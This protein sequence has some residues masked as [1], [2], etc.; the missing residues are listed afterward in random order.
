MKKAILFACTLTLLLSCSDNKNKKWEVLELEEIAK[1]ALNKPVRFVTDSLLLN[2]DK[3]TFMDEPPGVISSVAVHYNNE[4][5]IE[6]LFPGTSIISNNLG[7]KEEYLN[8]VANKIINEVEWK[9][10]N[11]TKGS[12]KNVKVY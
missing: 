6:F 4:G 5:T 7:S 1:F 2:A 8:K 12:I 10:V 3:L 11:G 9:N